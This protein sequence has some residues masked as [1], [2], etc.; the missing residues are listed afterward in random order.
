[1]S[2]VL[3]HAGNPNPRILRKSLFIT[4]QPV[5]MKALWVTEAANRIL[6]SVADIAP[7]GRPYAVQVRTR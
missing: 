1:V 6:Y 4:N 2:L 5:G 3:R 7:A